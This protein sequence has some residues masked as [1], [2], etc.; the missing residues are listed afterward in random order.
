MK[1]GPVLAA[2]VLLFSA[3][4]AAAKHKAKKRAPAKAEAAAKHP[5]ASKKK[6]PPPRKDFPSSCEV[7]EFLAGTPAMSPKERQPA[8]VA[9]L[10]RFMK[11][12]PPKNRDPAWL[13]DY[14]LRRWAALFRS[15]GDMDVLEAVD[16]V[17]AE[18][19]S[20]PTIC[21]LFYRAVLQDTRAVE[22]Y[23]YQAK[24]GRL[25]MCFEPDELERRL[26][27]PIQGPRDTNRGLTR[28]TACETDEVLPT[29]AKEPA[30]A[31]RVEE[32]VGKLG[33]GDDADLAGA[34]YF[35]TSLALQFREHPDEAILSGFDSASRFTPPEKRACELYAA[36]DSKAACA[37]YK[38]HYKTASAI[39]ARCLTD[40]VRRCLGAVTSSGEKRD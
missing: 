33:D 13:R 36:A 37:V 19:G 4:A 3:G 27:L 38:D 18:V 11:A 34:K 24:R 2:A 28:I 23:R 29:L 7:D 26:A 20:E 8:A 14:F 1:L 9:L 12:P 16:E 32:L 5:T 21:T 39:P 30:R 22:Y 40:D 15:R 25:S 6:E 10:T 35:F 31:H 17:V